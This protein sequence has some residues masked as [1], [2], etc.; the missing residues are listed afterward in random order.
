MAVTTENQKHT[1]WLWPDQI[2][3]KKRSRALREDHNATIRELERVR[4][5][6]ADLLAACTTARDEL[7]N[8]CPEE[9][10][11]DAMKPR[12]RAVYCVLR[13]AIAKATA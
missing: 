7:L 1:T 9:R 10:P 8:G 4:A 2:I 3:W 6:N 11:T 13:A 12:E 5:I